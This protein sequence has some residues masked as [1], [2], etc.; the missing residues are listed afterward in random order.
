MSN[1]QVRLLKYKFRTGNTL[2]GVDA[3]DV[4]E[5]LERIHAQHGSLKPADIVDESRPEDAVLH[6]VFEW[7]DQEAA[8][9]YRKWQA[10]YL[11]RSV[12][13]VK[14]DGKTDSA[15]VHVQIT[16]GYQPMSVVVSTPDM[17]QSA[18]NELLTKVLSAERAASELLEIVERNDA[19]KSRTVRKAKKHIESAGAAIQAL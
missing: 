13:T 7:D 9:E 6:P 15:F 18:K 11:V 3:Q 19:T 4:G 14:E 12:V 16:E 1:R 10:R 5:E 8:E 17:L 2:A